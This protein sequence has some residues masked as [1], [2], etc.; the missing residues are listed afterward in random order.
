MP[1]EPQLL[2][3][4]EALGVDAVLLIS[5]CSLG[6]A[7]RDLLK[8]DARARAALSDA[9]LEL[10]QPLQQGGPARAPRPS[11]RLE[12]AAGR[13]GRA[14]AGLP[15][16][17]CARD[18]G[19]EL[20]RVLRRARTGRAA[21]PRWQDDPLPRVRRRTSRA[22]SPT[23]CSPSGWPP[24]GPRP[25]RSSGTRRSS[26]GRTRA[27]AP[28]AAGGPSRPTSRSSEA[29]SS[30]PPAWPARSPAVD[31]VVALNTSGEL[32]AAIAGLPVVTFRAGRRSAGPGGLRPLRIPAGAERRLRD[33]LSRPRRARRATSAASS[34]GEHDRGRQRAF[35]E[36]FVRPRG[37]DRPVSPAVAD[38]I[39]E[40]AAR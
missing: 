15:A 19:A 22:R 31:A 10:G 29:R 38:T 13:R 25:T 4:V 16:R 1:A 9:R 27:A 33:R 3:A 6:G 8:V 11:A 5:R 20:R 26:S 18:R 23:W 35:V 7:E 14:A 12:R 39:L 30:R 21:R 17:A 28:G 2:D 37:I 32:E 24:S 34:D 40:R 36:S